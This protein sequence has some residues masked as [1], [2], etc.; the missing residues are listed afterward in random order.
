[1]DPMGG[2]RLGPGGVL[3]GT[4]SFGGCADA[5]QG[6]VFELTP[7]SVAGNLWNRIFL[8]PFGGVAGDGNFPSGNLISGP[9]GTLY[10]T[11][12]FGGATAVTAGGGDGTVYSVAAPSGAGF[13]IETILHSFPTASCLRPEW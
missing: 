10:G 1:M 9:D 3:Y 11:T 6:L 8:Y 12:Q 13:W 7:P 2:L 5:Q 4:A